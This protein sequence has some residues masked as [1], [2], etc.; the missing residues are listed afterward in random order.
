MIV[1]ERC[2]MSDI[3]I[4]VDSFVECL[5]HMSGI[6]EILSLS[7]AENVIESL[8]TQQQKIM[9][10]KALRDDSTFIQFWCQRMSSLTIGS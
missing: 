3:E 6:N 1:T 2:M 4:T 10:G 7:C 8:Q 5:K 9:V